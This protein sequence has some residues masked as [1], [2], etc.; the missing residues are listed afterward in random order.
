MF[1]GV[2]AI[3]ADRERGCTFNGF[4]EIDIG[5]DKGLVGKIDAA[6]HKTVIFRR[7]LDGEGDFFARV[8][9]G[10]FE[11]GSIGESV[12]HVGHGGAIKGGSRGF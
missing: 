10:A 3:G 7:G 9:R 4:H 6:E 12:L 5:R 2:D 11:R 1:D 8:K